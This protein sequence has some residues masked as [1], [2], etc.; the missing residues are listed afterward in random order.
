MLNQALGPAPN[1][2]KI[3]FY[4]TVRVQ[5]GSL[6]E[7][8]ALLAMTMQNQQCPVRPLNLPQLFQNGPWLV[9]WGSGWGP[10]LENVLPLP[11]Y[12]KST[13]LNQALGPAP[14]FSKIAL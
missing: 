10:E 6:S 4:R 1:F 14:N 13:M 7:K 3:A 9:Y 8:C 12:R 2:S 11:R 5:V